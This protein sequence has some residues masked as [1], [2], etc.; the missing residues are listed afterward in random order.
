MATTRRDRR[1]RNQ[2]RSGLMLGLAG[3]LIA[4]LLVYQ[5]FFRS[6]ADGAPTPQASPAAAA[7]TTG[8]AT[9]TTTAPLEP[10]LPNGSFD[11]LSLRDPFEPVGQI[12]PL[13]PTTTTTTTAGTDTPTTSTTL[14]L[15][16]AGTTD[17]AMIDIYVDPT[18][19]ARTARIRVGTAEYTVTEGQQ[20]ATNYLLVRFTSDTCADLTYASSRLHALHRPADRQVATGARLHRYPPGRN[21][22]RPEPGAL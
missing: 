4:S 11:E 20:F 19:G 3:A 18:S 21:G 14:S 2:Q 5:V 10:S 1:Q 13:E 15:N 22:S 7:S 6:S 17:V 16:P 8:D 9:T 12:T